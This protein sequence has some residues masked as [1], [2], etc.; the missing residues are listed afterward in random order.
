MSMA[1]KREMAKGRI[2]WQGDIFDADGQRRR[3]HFETKWEAQEWEAEQRTLAGRRGTRERERSK[4]RTATLRE[5]FDIWFPQ[6]TAIEDATRASYA[7]LFTR[8]VA[9]TLGRMKVRD[10]H[11]GHIRTLLASKRAAGLSANTCR[12]IRAVVSVLLG[13]AVADGIIAEN[14]ARALREERRKRPDHAVATAEIITPL[15]L[16]DLAACLTAAAR[17]WTPRDQVLLLTLADAGLRPSEALALQW[18]DGVDTI[19]RVL[20]IQRALS[21]SGRLKTTKTGTGRDVDM[22]PRLAATL[23]SWQATLEAEALLAGTTPSATVFASANGTYLDRRNV[24]RSFR[25]LLRRAAL[26]KHRLYDLRHTFASHLL[27]AG[28]PITYVSAQLGHASSTT[29]LKWYAHWMPSG[30][31]RWSEQLQAAR[32]GL[33]VT[34]VTDLGSAPETRPAM[35][36]PNSPAELLGEAAR[37][38]RGDVVIDDHGVEAGLHAEHDTFHHGQ[39]VD[40]GHHVVDGLHRVPRAHRPHA[41]DVGADRLQNRPH[42]IEDRRVA[43]HHDGQGGCPGSGHP[44]A[45]RR[46]QEVH[47]PGPRARFQLARGGGQHAAEIDE[48]RAGPGQV[49]QAARV[50]VEGL[51][52]R[53]GRQ[54]RHHDLGALGDLA[55]GG[56]AMRAGLDE[57]GHGLGILVVDG[58][59]EAAL[60]HV[61]RHGVA[62]VSDADEPYRHGHVLPPSPRSVRCGPRVRCGSCIPC[63]SLRRGRR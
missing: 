14:P 10:L 19:G 36:M 8:H 47:A 61:A 7:R 21:A 43:A 26:P 45:H 41:E 20:H 28:A 49:D 3:Q 46:F 35:Q 42:A 53:R 29:T 50:Q 58:H 1:R 44:A 24:A 63:G 39:G 32:T 37:I 15:T 51:D 12:L 54:A 33:P 22:T 9:P 57:V 18:E 34:G 62:H 55:D 40:A 6:Q 25:A 60:Q 27:A 52:V 5:W 4:H 16:G 56:G 30:G 31:Q 11:K 2:V 23:S 38:G 17:W 48:D 13:D 59:G